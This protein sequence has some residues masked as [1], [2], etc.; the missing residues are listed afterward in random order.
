MVGTGGDGGGGGE[1]PVKAKRM[2][3][4]YFF[5]FFSINDKYACM[6]HSFYPIKI[7]FQKN[8]NPKLNLNS[9]KTCA[10]Q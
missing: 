6:H 10:Q 8:P 5:T 1:P 4:L 9:H 3:S 7:E 2:S